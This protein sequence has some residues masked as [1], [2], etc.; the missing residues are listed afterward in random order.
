MDPRTCLLRK[1]ISSLILVVAASSARSD[2][3]VIV[4]L[5]PKGCEYSHANAVGS[6]GQAGQADIIGSLWHASLWN[7]TAGSWVDLNPA[8]SAY[9][10]VRGVSGG[11]QAGFA[12][13]DTGRAGI[14]NGTAASW[15]DLHPAVA[16]V[17]YADDVDGNQQ[18]GFC[19]IGGRFHASLWT[20]TAAS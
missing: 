11:Y 17:S 5:H 14:W 16:R 7:G 3:W 15:V 4:D 10:E 8:G 2:H 1:A 6:G 20:S 9:S 12:R 13:F 18:V 19:E